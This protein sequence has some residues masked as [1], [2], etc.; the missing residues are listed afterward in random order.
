MTLR[1]DK[2]I[3]TGVERMQQRPIQDLIDGLEQLGAKIK[4]NNGCPP[5]TIQGNKN[6]S[7]EITMKGDKSSQ[8]FSAMMQIAPCL[9][10]GLT[11]NVKGDLV[12]KPYLDIT[13][14][15]MRDFGVQVENHN[16]KKFIIPSQKY[17]ATKF[18][19]E[20]DASGASYWFGLAA[21]TGSTVTV[22]N[23]PYDAYQGDVKFVDVME[24]MGC[25]VEK[26][27]RSL[28]VTGPK[29]LKPLGKIRLNH[30][31]DAAM[32]VA[33]IAACA[34]GESKIVDVENMRIKETDR[35]TALVTEMKKMGIDCEEL[36]D[37]LI[38]RGNSNLATRHGAEI[39]TYDDHRMAMC[40][41]VLG[42]V[43]P[44]TIILNPEC[45]SKTYPTFFKEWEKI[46][47]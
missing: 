4:S 45:C 36:P 13:I 10:H 39:E 15:V 40:F 29:K 2:T 19:T 5:V 23:I 34:D 22:K 28:R 9:P 37:G 35:I 21:V 7:S 8:Y 42:C 11:I 31:P 32:T 46:Y 24:K 3:I 41:A 30:I 16:Y 27:E 47:I 14:N 43:T 12:S 20:G 17:K 44:G 18:Y 25:I 33:V 26:L 6:I 1:K 38:I